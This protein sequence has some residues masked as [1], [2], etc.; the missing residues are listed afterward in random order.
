MNKS[1]IYSTYWQ[2]KSEEEINIMK[3]GLEDGFGYDE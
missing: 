1:P 3:I 2:E